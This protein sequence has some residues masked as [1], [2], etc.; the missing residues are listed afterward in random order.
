MKTSAFCSS[1]NFSVNDSSIAI[2]DSSDIVYF[3]N[4]F[5]RFGSNILSNF[6]S[7]SRLQ[8]G[9]PSICLYIMISII[10]IAP[11]FFRG[12][13]PLLWV[14]WGGNSVHFCIW[15][16]ISVKDVWTL[17][18]SIEWS[19]ALQMWLKPDLSEKDQ[20]RR[21]Q[22]HSLGLLEQKTLLDQ[23]LQK[24]RWSSRPVWPFLIDQLLSLRLI[25]NKFST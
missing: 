2:T 18:C 11:L 6:Y 7:R 14:G 10:L 5:N 22:R 21:Y 1:F 15:L 9:W 13:Y 17:R 8:H 24:S 23:S 19:T 20:Y 16:R 12:D 25:I 3:D 4:F